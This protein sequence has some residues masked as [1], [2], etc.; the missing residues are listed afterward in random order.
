MKKSLVALAVAT[1]VSTPILAAESQA[2]I[3]GDYGSAT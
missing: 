2:Y 3:Y 1:L